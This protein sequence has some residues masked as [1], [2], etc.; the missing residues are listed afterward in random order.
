MLAIRAGQMFDGERFTDGRVTV[1]VDDGRLSGVESGWP[2]LPDATQV[3]DY[4]EDTVLPGLIDTHAH[5]VCDS[6]ENALLRIAGYSAAETRRG[7]H[8]GAPTSTGRRC[9]DGPG[10]GGPWVLCA[11]AA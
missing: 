5:L 6:D 2:D 9:D 4:P 3:L 1:L 11:G 10:P 7:H 8:R